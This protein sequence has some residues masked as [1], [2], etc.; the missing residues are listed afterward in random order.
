MAYLFVNL[1]GHYEQVDDAVGP[2]YLNN[3]IVAAT[4]GYTTTSFGSYIVGNAVALPI[5]LSS[6]TGVAVPNVGVRL[7][8]QTVSEL[9]NYG[10]YVQRKG[11]T[12]SSWVELPNSF[13]S[14][15]GTTNQPHEYSFV[16]ST[17]TRGVWQYR[18]HQVDFDG[19]SH[20]L[21]AITVSV[22]TGVQGEHTPAEFALKQNYPNPFNPATT[23]SF[24]IPTQ[25]HVTLSVFDM[26]GREITTLVNATRTAGRYAARFDAND[27]ASGVY[28]YQ[29]TTPSY[30]IVKRMVFIR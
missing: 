27:L 26:T 21:E 19:T 4:L 15:N 10:F 3:P 25:S 13:T 12:D 11:G 23:I 17:A 2:P 14:G 28:F 9:N 1:T 22:V 5:Q 7:D 29:L 18:L 16:D 20:Y 30:S 24:E 6:F 8:W